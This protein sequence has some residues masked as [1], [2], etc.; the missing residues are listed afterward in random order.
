MKNNKKL[1][2]CLIAAFIMLNFIS[3][4]IGRS[5]QI[6]HLLGQDTSLPFVLS[7]ILFALFLIFNCIFLYLASVY[8]NIAVIIVLIL[9]WEIALFEQ[10]VTFL[11]Y[12]VGHVINTFS[13]FTNISWISFVIPDPISITIIINNVLTSN[14]IISLSLAQI[15][16]VS[17]CI[18][19]LFY[20]IILLSIKVYNRKAKGPC[21]K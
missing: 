18:L 7:C 6:L 2:I 17:I 11:P 21:T 19:C 5:P 14:N 9:H 8:N 15:I 16:K 4:Y 3:Y 10:F 13:I 12:G 1:I 20:L